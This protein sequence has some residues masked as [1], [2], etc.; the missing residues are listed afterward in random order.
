M[1]KIF[2]ALLLSICVITYSDAQSIDKHFISAYNEIAEMLDGK[3]PLSIKR[4][5]FLTEWAYLDGE[6]DY[7]NYSSQIEST[8]E[9][10]KQFYIANNLDQFKTG[11]N[12]AL[13]EYFSKPYSMNDYKHFTYD[14]ED[15][16]GSEDFTKLFVTKVMRTHSGQCHSLPLY[17]KVLAEVVGAE[18]YLSFVPQHVFIRHRDEQDPTKWINV[19]LTSQS[20]SREIYYIES[21]GITD[22]AIRNKLYMYPLS[23]KET[24]AYLLTCLMDGYYRKYKQWDNFVL[25]CA[26]KSLQYYP[27]NFHALTMKANVINTELMNHLIK[28]GKKDEKIRELDAQWLA[29]EKKLNELGWKRSIDNDRY[30]EIIKGVEENMRKAGIDSKTIQKEIN[31]QRLLDKKPVLK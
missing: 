22:D 27:Q 4:A 20:L 21:F 23:D 29:I 14:F 13:F 17:Y 28:N 19:E 7:S 10:I 8:A 9:A 16:A 2:L 24:V 1:R 11:L 5:V 6:L 18:A 3:V 31:K 26:E 15:F 25:R 12:V 30:E